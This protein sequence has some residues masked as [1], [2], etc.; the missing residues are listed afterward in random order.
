MLP[1]L[2][3]I[4]PWFRKKNEL[5]KYTEL[6]GEWM[7]TPLNLTF[8]FD[9][10]IL[11]NENSYL[12]HGIQTN[13]I[14]VKDYRDNTVDVYIAYEDQPNKQSFIHNTD[15]YNED[16]HTNHHHHH[17]HHTPNLHKLSCYCGYKQNIVL[18]SCSKYNVYPVIDFESRLKLIDP[19]I[20]IYS[21]NTIQGS[22]V[23]SCNTRC[24]VEVELRELVINSVITNDSYDS[25]QDMNDILEMG[26]L[27]E[28]NIERTIYEAYPIRIRK[29][30][31][32]A[33]DLVVIQS[34][35][36]AIDD[37]FNISDLKK[38]FS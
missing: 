15:N 34:C 31:S 30:K 32:Y 1:L 26:N 2:L 35:I 37:K 7:Y 8:K 19:D 25:K 13:M 3:F 36:D 29:D 24:I 22:D 14:K 33:N 4:K 21:I 17:Q 16:I 5:S 27:S 20:E 6:K 9:G 11:T 23:T 18:L 10:F 28:I 38:I 12:T